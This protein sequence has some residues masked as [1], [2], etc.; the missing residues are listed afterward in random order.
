M[1]GG[2]LGDFGATTTD[3]AVQTAGDILGRFADKFLNVRSIL[4]LVI[5]L[6]VALVLGRLVAF[7]LR[8]LVN[9]IGRS[10]DKTEDLNTVNR[11]R[12]YETILV[13]S[14]AVVRGLLV[15]AALYFW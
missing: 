9:F 15:I 2:I 6:T 14:I 13:L 8:R 10:A 5:A 1:S 12:R 7:V 11:L 4:V 3:H